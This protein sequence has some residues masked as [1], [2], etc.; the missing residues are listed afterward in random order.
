MLSKSIFLA[1]FVM[2]STG[3]AQSI[4]ISGTV[5][6]FAGAPVANAQIALGTGGLTASSDAQGR[7]TLTNGTG[8]GE[9]TISGLSGTIRN[10]FLNLRLENTVQGNSVRFLHNGGE[11]S[12]QSQTL[13]TGE[14]AIPLYGKNGYFVYRLTADEK[15]FAF[16]PTLLADKPAAPAARLQRRFESDGRRIHRS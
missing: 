15:E 4:R 2:I 11:A 9:P 14:H 3:L 8:I 1:I 6:N 16:K 7:F 10:G 13:G 5:T 12:S